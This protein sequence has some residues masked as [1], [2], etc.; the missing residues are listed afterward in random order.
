MLLDEKEKIQ[1]RAEEEEYQHNHK[2]FQAKMTAIFKTQK[3]TSST[4]WAVFR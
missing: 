1:K 2:M 3:R 4:Q